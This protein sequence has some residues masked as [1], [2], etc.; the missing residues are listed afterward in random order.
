MRRKHAVS[1][2]EF[3]GLWRLSRRIAD[4][5]G[6]TEGRF[7]GQ[8]RLAPGPDGAAGL[9]YVEEGKLFLGDAAPLAATRRLLWQPA[10]DGGIAVAF[11]DGRPFHRIRPGGLMP[12]DTHVCGA[13]LYQVEYDFR[14]WPAWGVTWRV[15][16]PRKDYSLQSRY[17]R[18]APPA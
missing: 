4:R 16:G 15:V 13:D 10:A 5:R 3:A 2:A 1:L 12:V 9:V 6:K 7:E 11:A 14:D 8:A 17:S 18:E